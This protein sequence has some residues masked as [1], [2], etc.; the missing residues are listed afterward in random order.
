M[1]Y[2]RMKLKR[3]RLTS[4]EGIRLVRGNRQRG[5]DPWLFVIEGSGT[6]LV[7]KRRYKPE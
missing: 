1:L 2:R 4:S 7:K 6:A 5:A 3:K